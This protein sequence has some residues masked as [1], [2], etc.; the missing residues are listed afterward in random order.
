MTP[1]NFIGL[2]KSRR[3]IR[4]WKTK[5][6]PDDLSGKII[7]CGRYAPSSFDSQPWEIIVLKDKEKIK[8]LLSDRLQM[9]EPP[10]DINSYKYARMEGLEK[11]QEVC[12]PPVML[13][14]CGDNKKC[15][16]LGSLLCSLS[17]CVENM[18]LAA[19]ALDLGA[20]WL[21]VYDPDTPETEKQIK[22]KLKLPKHI[23]V[24]CL[25]PIGYPD[26]K[27][28]PKEIRKGTVHFDKWR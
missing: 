3:S 10:Y 18:L 11:Y 1:K 12:L 9:K 2:I 7:D 4:K 25:I 16:Y 24:L 5:K 6:V 19:H 28:L 15:P 22:K 14:I 21:Y 13:V 17:C 20:C 8:D 27:P 23:T 26:E